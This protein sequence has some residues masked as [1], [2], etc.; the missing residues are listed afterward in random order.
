MTERIAA[1]DIGTNSTKMTVGEVDNGSV[2]PILETSETTRLGKGVDAS[3]KLDPEAI[4]RTVEAV[5]RFHEQAKDLGADRVLAAGTS[6]LRDAANGKDFLDDVHA[7]TGITVVIITGDREANLA[8]SAIK[9]D[10]SITLSQDSENVVFDIGGGSTELIVGTKDAV[11]RFQSLNIGAVRLTERLL[12]SDPPTDEEVKRVREEAAPAIAEFG[13]PKAQSVV[14]IGGTAVNVAAVVKGS[15]EDLH[16]AVVTGEQ[17]RE[18]IALFL[19]KTLEERRKLPGLEPARAD[20]IAAGAI[21]LDELLNAT[22][23]SS[24]TVS[25]RGLRFGL[26]ASAIH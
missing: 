11:A 7:K 24:F 2:S 22:G 4:K 18:T 1:I 10:S 12:R 14:G 9:S 17:L 20:V 23:A 5:V 21:I 26:I 13:P 15:N 8:Y 19:S 16:G 6:A 25:V 3:G